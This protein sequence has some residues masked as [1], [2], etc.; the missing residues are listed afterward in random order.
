[1]SK[2]EDTLDI[3]GIDNVQDVWNRTVGDR[4]DTVQDQTLCAVNCRHAVYSTAV[5]DGDEVAF[6]P[7]V[8]GG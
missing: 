5:D 7:P 8:T 1:M 2:S 4:S 3:S 6:F